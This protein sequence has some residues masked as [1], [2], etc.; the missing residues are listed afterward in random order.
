M[1]EESGFVE[2]KTEIHK[3]DLFNLVNLFQPGYFKDKTSD[4]G[5]YYGIYQVKK[6]VFQTR[7][8]ISFWNFIIKEK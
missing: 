6:L 8:E 7:K 1:E 3:V 2:L 4:L 5:N